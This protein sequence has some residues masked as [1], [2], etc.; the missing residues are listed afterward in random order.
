MSYPLHEVSSN[1]YPDE[2]NPLHPAHG[3]IHFHSHSEC[4][5]HYHGTRSESHPRRRLLSCPCHRSMERLPHGGFRF[6]HIRN[7]SRVHSH[8]GMERLDDDLRQRIRN[9]TFRL[10][11]RIRHRISLH[12]LARTF[13]RRRKSHHKVRVPQGHDRPY[14]QGR[15]RAS[16]ALRCG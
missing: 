13:G 16:V 5:R 8:S 10:R 15:P 3:C 9:A 14:Q 2:K 7:Q 12:S 4:K 1:H 6:R 11:R